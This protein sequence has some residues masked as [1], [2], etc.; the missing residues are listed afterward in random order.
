MCKRADK[1]ALMAMSSINTLR[2]YQVIENGVVHDPAVE[3]MVKAFEQ[4]EA[5]I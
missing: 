5:K 2:E 1:P 3:D 4:E